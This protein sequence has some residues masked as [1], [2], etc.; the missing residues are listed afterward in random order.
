MVPHEY[1][2][3]FDKPP[4]RED[5]RYPLTLLAIFFAAFLLI[6]TFIDTP[7]GEVGAFVPAINAIQFAA[8]L[9]LATMLYPQ[10]NIFHSRA[11]HILASG[12]IFIAAL[13][14]P[15]VLTFPGAL[16]PNGLFGDGINTP[17]WIM[18]FRRLGFPAMII[19]Y[20]IYDEI[21]R[22]DGAVSQAPRASVPVWISGALL[23]AAASSAIPALRPDFFPPIFSD[24]TQ[25]VRLNLLVF[26]VSNIALI[27][28]AMTM[29]IRKRRSMLDIWLLVSLAGWLFQ[30][31][32]NLPLHARFTVGWYALQIFILVSNL[33]VL[34][35]MVAEANRL[36]ARLALSTAAQNRE[37]DARL[38]TI[39]GMASAISHELGQP[40][41]AASAN[42]S[43]G[44]IWMTRDEPD[45]DK[46]IEAMR[47]SLEA[48]RLCF[49][50]LRNMRVTLAR[51]ALAS[52][53]FN[54]A[55]LLR[56]TASLVAPELDNAR[57]PLQL[58]CPENL[59]D[60]R[61]NRIQA[62]RVLVT[63]IN[64]AIESMAATATQ[65]HCLTIRAAS[66][67][68]GAVVIDVIDTGAGIPPSDLAKIF[69]AFYT[70]KEMGTGLGLSLCR[71]IIEEHGGFLWA[72][73]GVEQGAVFRLRLPSAGPCG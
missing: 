32:L 25:A 38:M 15:Y 13:I 44:L 1:L 72:T 62:Q 41:T 17:A 30:S 47:S 29:L 63:L 67:E 53:H 2:G 24:R 49:E 61:G 16:A 4:G 71:T 12:F 7:L 14:V 37:R 20:A 10:A 57:I 9:I 33:C 18:I 52:T 22:A 70:T 3:L 56:E 26:N 50:V 39:D 40:L 11:L 6:L 64:N 51:G 23:L 69:E 36:S 66:D 65:P 42:V 58:A 43:A 54:V 68:G 34:I 27:L 60:V 19:C 55:E 73:P 21:D 45:R 28:A 8:E 35:A 48:I 5:L 31:L 46:A 59:P